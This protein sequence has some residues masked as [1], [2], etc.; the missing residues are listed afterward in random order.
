MPHIYSFHRAEDHTILAISQAGNIHEVAAKVARSLNGAADET[1][2]VYVHNGMRIAAAGL[3]R[4][5]V[6]H[7][8][9]RDDYAAFEA[10]ARA[11]RNRDGLPNSPDQT[12]Q[13]GGA[14]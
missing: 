5:G 11:E 2:R 13:K 4:K 1:R 6:W 9:M 8:A 14:A 7:D 12:D 3:C 10:K